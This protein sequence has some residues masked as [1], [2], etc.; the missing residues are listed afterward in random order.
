RAPARRGARHEIH[1]GSLRAH[2][3]ARISLAIAARCRSSAR[4]SS[5]GA[6]PIT[7]KRRSTAVPVRRRL[8]AGVSVV[9]T[10]RL[11]GLLRPG[12]R[13]GILL[14]RGG[15]RRGRRRRLPLLRLSAV[16]RGVAMI[17]VVAG[18]DLSATPAIAGIRGTTQEP[19]EDTVATAFVGHIEADRDTPLAPRGGRLVRASEENECQQAGQ[20]ETLHR[21]VLSSI[22]NPRGG[23]P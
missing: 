16:A 5:P 19:P 7:R 1:T 11:G 18:V 3:T 15:R 9:I 17:A 23:S 4:G 6:A 10:D 20:E 21:S 13:G 8:V 12:G 22:P 2:H 14:G